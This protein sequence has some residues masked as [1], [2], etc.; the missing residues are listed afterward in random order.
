LV[1]LV[2]RN[3]SAFDSVELSTE[4]QDGHPEEKDERMCGACST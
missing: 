2:V 3:D 4:K 1:V